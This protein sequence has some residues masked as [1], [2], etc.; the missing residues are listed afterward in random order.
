MALLCVRGLGWMRLPTIVFLRAIIFLALFEARVAF[1]STGSYILT[2][3]R[4]EGA[5][6]A[7]VSPSS[8]Q[9]HTRSAYFLIYLHIFY[10]LRDERQAARRRLCA[11]SCCSWFAL[12]FNSSCDRSKKYRGILT[13]AP[14]CLLFLVYQVPKKFVCFNLFF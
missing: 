9:Y 6:R 3:K 11:Y 4:N 5:P 1:L 8:L 7:K 2:Q 10:S 12:I 14:V 13:V